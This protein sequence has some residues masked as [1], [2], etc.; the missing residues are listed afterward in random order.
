MK[1][2]YLGIFLLSFF[3]LFLGACNEKKT[4]HFE[5]YSQQSCQDFQAL[6]ATYSTNML[7]PLRPNFL[8]EKQQAVFCNCLDKLLRQKVKPKYNAAQLEGMQNFQQERLELLQKVLKNNDE[9]L[10]KCLEKQ[11]INEI[12]II[13]RFLKSLKETEGKQTSKQ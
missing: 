9:R 13:G 6:V 12:R 8:P 4:D 2:A 10:M 11:E 5:T 1:Y 7:V 3:G